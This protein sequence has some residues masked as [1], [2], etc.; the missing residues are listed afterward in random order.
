MAVW[1]DLRLVEEFAGPE[2]R[3]W[4]DHATRA[5]GQVELLKD[6]YAELLDEV[7]DEASRG[8]RTARRRLRTV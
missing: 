2:K 6:L 4:R 7:I 3:A 1:D 5:E 8:T